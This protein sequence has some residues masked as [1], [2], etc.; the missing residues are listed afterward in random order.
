MK[1]NGFD[2][3][4]DRRFKSDIE[5]FRASALA[6]A[7]RPEIFWAEQRRLVMA[8]VGQA[9]KASPFKPALVWAV[10]A[11]ILLAAVGLW[12]ERPRALPAPDFAAGYDDDLLADVERL[13]DMQTPLAL[14]PAMELV[15]E[16]KAGLRPGA[17]KPLR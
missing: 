17:G 10:A 5:E 6:G 16:I 13:T 14:Q 2:F 15:D 7:D 8:R 1:K 12:M 3:A 11:V 4:G 9:R